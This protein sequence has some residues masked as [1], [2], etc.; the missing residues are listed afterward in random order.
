MGQILQRW[1]N[2]P[3]ISALQECKVQRS[4]LKLQHLEHLVYPGQTPY[5]PLQVEDFGVER[6]GEEYWSKLSVIEMAPYGPL[7]RDKIN[8]WEGLTAPGILVIEEMKRN[9]GFYMSEISQAVYENPFPLETLKQIFVLDVENKDTVQ[10]VSERLYTTLSGLQ[11]PDETTRYWEYGTPEFKGLLGTKIGQVVAH[12]ILGA[13]KRGTRRIVRIGTSFML[14]FLQMRFDIEEICPITLPHPSQFIGRTVDEK[15]Q[16]SEEQKHYMAEWDFPGQ[17]LASSYHLR[18][19]EN[20]ISHLHVGSVLENEGG[21]PQALRT[22]HQPP[23]ILDNEATDPIYI[24][25]G[26]KCIN[27]VPEFVSVLN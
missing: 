24:N 27:V 3:S 5:H 16:L 1:M 26:Q 20:T 12:M 21:L 15:P 25:D 23:D 11:W 10:F 18:P 13:F 2:D 8:V 7:P 6:L 22:L 4:K 19:V 9:S 17:S 14:D